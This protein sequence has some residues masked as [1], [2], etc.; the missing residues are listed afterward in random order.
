MKRKTAEHILDAFVNAVMV[1]VDNF[2]E[3]RQA[4]VIVRRSASELRNVILDAME[5]D[6]KETEKIAIIL[7][8]RDIPDMPD[9]MVKDCQLSCGHWTTT[10]SRYCP[11]CGAK[12]VG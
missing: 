8:T 11:H 6:E 3:D 7:Q 2:I 10:F 5:S 9:S 1:T 4:S 12:V